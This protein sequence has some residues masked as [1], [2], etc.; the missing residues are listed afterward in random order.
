MRE[1]LIRVLI[2]A[3][4]IAVTA[5]LIPNIYIANNDISTLLIIGLI[6]GVVNSLLKP[7]LISVDLPGGAAVAGA[8]HLCHQ[9]AS[10]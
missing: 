10:C 4:A 5:L 8:V 3:V 7:L 2:N 1:F 9:R 6:F